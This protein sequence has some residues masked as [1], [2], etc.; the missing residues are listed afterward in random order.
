MKKILVIENDP[1]ILNILEIVLNDLGYEV[2]AAKNKIPI[3]KIIVDDPGLILLDY[4][5]DDGHGKDLCLELKANP[6]TKHIPLVIMSAHFDVAQFAI[7][8]CA[9]AFISKPFDI[10]A[11][12]DLLSDMVA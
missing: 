11:L 8:S 9:D 7:E 4:F 2:I 1:D 5:L 12:G 3:E 6:L 10:A